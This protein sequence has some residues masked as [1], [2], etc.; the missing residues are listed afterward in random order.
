MAAYGSQIAQGKSPEQAVEFLHKVLAN[1]PVQDK[2][3][4]EALQTFTGGKGDV[5]LAYENEAINAR[6][7]EQPVD[8]VVPDS[9]ILIE[10]PIAVAS[11]S[12]NAAAAWLAWR[13][14]RL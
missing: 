7:K 14:T 5:M 10:N 9:T 1:T 2:S 12:R 8:Y 6:Q 13:R 4:R 3:A 11:K